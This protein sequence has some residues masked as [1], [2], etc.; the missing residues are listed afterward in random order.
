M[1][2]DNKKVAYAIDNYQEEN[3]LYVKDLITGKI[4]K[5]S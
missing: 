1:C 4:L 2:P 5:Q 3:I